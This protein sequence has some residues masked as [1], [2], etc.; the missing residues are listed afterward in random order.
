MTSDAERRRLEEIE[1]VL[2]RDDPAFVGRFD[3]RR[4][5]AGRRRSVALLA[6]LVVLAV[7]SLAV[8]VGGAVAGVA[9]VCVMGLVRVVVALWRRLGRR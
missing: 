9:A 3:E 7:T 4:L 1:M 2:R 8:A 5:A 6:I